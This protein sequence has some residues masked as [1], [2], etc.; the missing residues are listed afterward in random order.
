MGRVGRDLALYINIVEKFGVVF[1]GIA[2]AH[3]YHHLMLK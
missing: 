1:D 2:R 3:E